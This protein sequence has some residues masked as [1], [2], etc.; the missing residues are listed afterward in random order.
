VGFAFFLMVTLSYK[1][2]F[3]APVSGTIE[4]VTYYY[5]VTIVFLPHSLVELRSQHIYVDLFLRPLSQKT[6]LWIYIF[7]CVLGII[8]FSGMTYQAFFD[9]VKAITQKETVMSNYLFYVWPSRCAL[10]MGRVSFFGIAALTNFKAAW[11]IISA[12]PF[13]FIGNWSFTAVPMF[14]LLGYICTNSGMT[15][16]LLSSLFWAV[17]SQ[18]FS[19]PRK[20]VPSAPWAPWSPWSPWTTCSRGCY[21][22]LPWTFS[23]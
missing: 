20:P 12:V 17:S 19:L 15:R 3:N 7:G 2:F 23:P 8:Y 5:M 21:G 18:E 10:P 9:A 22:S 4:V 13:N 6:Q 1:Y 11:V 14:L 16:S